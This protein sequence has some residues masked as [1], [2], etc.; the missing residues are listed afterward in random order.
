MVSD[1]GLPLQE[2]SITS[3]SDGDAATLLQSPTALRPIP[4]EVQKRSGLKSTRSLHI[5]SLILHFTL[6]GMHLVLLGIWTKHFERRL[7]F[8]L[9]H[10]TIVSFLITAISTTFGTIYLALLVYVTQTLSARKSLR[11]YQTLTA[12]H[13]NAAAWAGIG[14][15]TF[16]IWHQKAISAS[17]IGVVSVFFYLGNILVLHITTPA[18][19]SLQ[20]FNSTLSVPTITQGLPVL[21]SSGYNISEAKTLLDVMEYAAGS[22]YYLPYVNGST[23][24]GLH[25]GTLY[26]VLEANTGIN[27]V[28]VNATGFNITCGYLDDLKIE[29]SDGR[30]IATYSPYSGEE[31][32]TEIVTTQAGVI[33]TTP[34]SLSIVNPDVILY[35]TIPIIDS[36][37]KNGSW[38]KLTPPMNSSVSLIQVLRC[39]LSLVNQTAIVDPQS[40]KLMVVGP[41]IKK[42]DSSWL[43]YLEPAAM[44]EPDTDTKNLL[45]DQWGL[46]Y[47]SMPT[48]DF[49]FVPDTDTPQFI[50]VADLYLIQKLNLHPV[51]YTEAPRIV[52]LHDL[53][54]ALSALV[55]SMFWILGHIPPAHETDMTW[56]SLIQKFVSTVQEAQLGP[57][58]LLPGDTTVTTL[59]ART[60]LD[61]SIIAVV[62]GLGASVALLLLSNPHSIFRHA[63]ED[64]QDSV[65]D[66]TGLLHAI[67]LYRNHPELETLLDQVKY[68]TD[69]NLREAGMAERCGPPCLW[70]RHGRGPIPIAIDYLS[71]T[72]DPVVSLKGR[73]APIFNR[74]LTYADALASRKQFD[75]IWVPAGPI[76]DFAT[77]EH[78]I[79]L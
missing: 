46:W 45:I 12:T 24:I 9:D 36:D 52:R 75:V 8:S 59:S 56:D 77:G 71:T 73:N 16:Q 74:T 43:P 37:N 11:K 34:F 55:A 23:T 44:S 26:D 42:T 21:N 64:R 68:P 6:V 63:E 15:A 49:P 62:A 54:N 28:T 70:P 27:N 66:G 10:Q 20:T 7:V 78:G 2:M 35:S 72:V 51:N 69:E 25:E 13:D 39:S 3:T 40:G 38:T 5:L 17:F 57:V 67:W 14:S 29:Y 1:F 61:L 41:E 33:F 79:P 31:I 65:V 4:W 60:R 18:L 19:F 47:T 22:L 50:S 76:P 30:F 32:S 48:S 53:E 58:L